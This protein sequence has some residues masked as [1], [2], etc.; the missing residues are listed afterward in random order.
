MGQKVLFDGK[1]AAL[2]K[3]K[4]S[5]QS[6]ALKLVAKVETFVEQQRLSLSEGID[7][8]HLSALIFASP[9]SASIDKENPTATRLIQ[10][11]GRCRRPFKGKSK[12]F[13]LD[14]VDNHPFGKSAHYD[15]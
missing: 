3:I 6:D 10:S 12:A 8:P 15:H 1:P 4:K 13:V 7:L 14:L 9:V 5:K 11:I 2:L